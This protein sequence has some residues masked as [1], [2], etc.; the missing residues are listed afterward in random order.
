[1]SRHPSIFGKALH[2][3]GLG[4]RPPWSPAFM[5]ELIKAQTKYNHAQ[6]LIDGEEN[7]IHIKAHEATRVLIF[8]DMHGSF[9]SL[10][11]DLLYLRENGSLTD[12]LKITNNHLF[13]VFNGDFIDRSPHNIDSLILLTMLMGKNPN[14][15]IYVAGNHERDRTW[16]NYSLKQELVSRGRFFSKQTIPFDNEIMAFFSSL[17]SAIYLSG[18]QDK[19][20]SHSYIFLLPH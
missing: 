12:E 7:I 14:Q 15:V 1:M 5:A 19:K 13:L 16:N 9:H 2:F 6:G 4:K 17:P 8:G 18:S 11:R 10:L 20:R 3:L